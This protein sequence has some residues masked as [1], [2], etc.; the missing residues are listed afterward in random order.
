[1]KRIKLPS[2]ARLKELFDYDA[3]NGVLVWIDPTPSQLPF[4]DRKRNNQH[5]KVTRVD[6]SQYFESRLIWKWHFGTEPF[7]VDHID[8]NPQNNKIENLREGDSAQNQYNRELDRR[9]KSGAR[10]VHH[11]YSKYHNRDIWRVSVQYQNKRHRK[12]FPYTDQGKAAAIAWRE[13]KIKELNLQEWDCT[14]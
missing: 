14:K 5:R 11:I 6:G 3:E 8:R 7:L 1:M 13:Q 4:I 10:G 2:Q 9:N 12:E